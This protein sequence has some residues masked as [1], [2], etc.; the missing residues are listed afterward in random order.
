[1]TASLAGRIPDEIPAFPA[2]SVPARM[3]TPEK[4]G[5]LEFHSRPPQNV[6]VIPFEVLVEAGSLHLFSAFPHRKR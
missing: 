1:M 4:L 5:N 3:E 6:G 2:K